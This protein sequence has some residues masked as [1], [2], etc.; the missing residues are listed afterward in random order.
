MKHCMPKYSIVW[1]ADNYRGAIHLHFFQLALWSRVF[2]CFGGRLQQQYM[3]QDTKHNCS[4]NYKKSANLKNYLK[5]KF[6]REIKFTKK[7]V[8]LFFPFQVHCVNTT[9][10]TT[11]RSIIVCIIPTSFPVRKHCKN[12]I[13]IFGG[14]TFPDR[15][16]PCNPT[17]AISKTSSKFFYLW[18]T[19]IYQ[20]YSILR[21]TL[22]T[23]AFQKLILS[24]YIVIF[25]F[26]VLFQ[27]QKML[28]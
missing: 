24:K 5:F 11:S 20:F 9:T 18:L 13:L 17:C 10:T 26:C 3:L 12:V 15:F 6:F 8:A 16:I 27:Y 4:K 1:T 2:T 23:M 25:M 22:F 14:L 19:D 28:L 7:F 21:S